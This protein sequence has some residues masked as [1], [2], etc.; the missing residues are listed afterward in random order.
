MDQCVDDAN[1]TESQKFSCKEMF[2][3]EI[4]EF[5]QAFLPPN[6]PEPNISAGQVLDVAVGIT[7]RRSH[8]STNSGKKAQLLPKGPK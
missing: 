8:N 6:F 2:G 7:G 4:D 1:D 3:H 5:I